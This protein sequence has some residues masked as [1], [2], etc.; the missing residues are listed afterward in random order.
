[1]MPGASAT[2][3]P[4]DVPPAESHFSTGR[5]P[6]PTPPPKPLGQPARHHTSNPQRTRQPVLSAQ[7]CA[8]GCAPPRTQCTVA[9]RRVNG[10]RCTI[11]FAAGFAVLCLA[12]A[13]SIHLLVLVDTTVI[14]RS[15]TAQQ[16]AAQPPD[17]S[18]PA[19]A[20]ATRTHT[21]STHVRIHGE[22]GLSEVFLRRRLF[23]ICRV[24]GAGTPR[25][26]ALAQ[27]LLRQAPQHQAHAH[28]M[29]SQQRVRGDG[30][31]LCGDI[32]TAYTS[33]RGHWHVGY[34]TRRAHDEHTTSTRGVEQ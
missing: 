2:W 25:P 4:D 18:P 5:A 15:C 7:C 24:V 8:S 28:A 16:H 30:G 31:E 14:L 9:Y 26:P 23:R 33:C 13:V 34:Q 17:G 22:H 32:G 6:A 1:M 12:Q 10:R 21:H 27:C 19:W 11:A 3:N 20:R 29:T